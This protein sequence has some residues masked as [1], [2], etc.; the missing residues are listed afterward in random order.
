MNEKLVITA[1]E[2]WHSLLA[3]V[4]K[5]SEVELR[6]ALDIEM[7]HQRRKAM[8]IKLHQKFC[9]ART[10]REREELLGETA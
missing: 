5:M 3:S 7:T 6:A 2:G 8:M 10:Q 4:N 1:L 9:T